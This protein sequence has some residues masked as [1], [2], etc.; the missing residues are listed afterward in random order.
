MNRK[1]EILNLEHLYFYDGI[2]FKDGDPT[3]KGTPE[4]L[5]AEARNM[6]RE[7]SPETGEFF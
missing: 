4:Q 5:V 6:Y 7:L 1:K 2:N 3:P